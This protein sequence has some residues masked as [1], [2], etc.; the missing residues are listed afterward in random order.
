MAGLV[1]ALVGAGGSIATT[2]ATQRYQRAEARREQ[3]EKLARETVEAISHEFVALHELAWTYP[4]EGAPL[5]VMRPFRLMA[6]EHHQRILLAL[7]RLPDRA[8][9]E[10]VGDIAM[11][12][13][14]TF[15]GGEGSYLDRR[16]GAV[17]VPYEGLSCLGAFLREDP[18][19]PPTDYTQVVMARRRANE[20][21]TGGAPEAVSEGNTSQA[22]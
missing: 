14:L 4:A 3:R 11:A 12:S 13:A 1:G 7:P 8:L 15:Q 21:G 16:Q 6:N 22:Q 2:L 5:E 9:A 18:L 17:S 10:R 20:A 19:P